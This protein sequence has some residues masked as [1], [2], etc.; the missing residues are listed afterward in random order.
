MK[1]AYKIPPELLLS[2]PLGD[3]PDCLM[4]YCWVEKYFEL[5]LTVVCISGL[6]FEVLMV[7]DNKYTLSWSRK[8]F[9][10]LECIL[11]EYNLIRNNALVNDLT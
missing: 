6:L 11:P 5:V 3:F 10:I 4:A 9:A 1:A 2:F 7:F 8:Y